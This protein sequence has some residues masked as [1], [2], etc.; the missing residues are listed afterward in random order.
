MNLLWLSNFNHLRRHPWQFGLALIGV[1]LGVAI[2]VAVQ[3]TQHSAKLGFR[4]AQ[5]ALTGIATHRIEAATG[6][7]DERVYARL[8]LSFP[9][10]AMTPVLEADVKLAAKRGEWA[11]LVGLDPLTVLTRSSTALSNAAAAQSELLTTSLGLV[12]A[13]T[14]RLLGQ[15]ATATVILV[16]AEHEFVLALQTPAAASPLND[17][18]LDGVILVDIATAQ[19]LL[20]RPGEIS[21]IELYV[22]K[23]AAGL[24]ARLKNTLPATLHLRD[25]KQELA[26]QEMLTKALDT[27]LAA[28][29]FLG[30]LLGMFL[31]YN[32]ESFLVVQRNVLYG[33]LRTLGVTASELMWGVLIEALLIGALASVVGVC[34]GVLL[35]DAL[36]DLV[37]Y[38]RRDFY[39]AVTTHEL[40]LDAMTLGAC[41]VGG[42][43]TTILAALCPA[44]DAANAPL[45]RAPD[46][47]HAIKSSWL[48]KRVLTFSFILIA[49][50][51]YMAPIS[52]LWRSFAWLFLALVLASRLIPFALR[53]I[54]PGL[55]RALRA[56]SVWPERL[57]IATSLRADRRIE[58]ATT[59]LCLAAAVSLG[60][61]LMTGSFRQNVETWLLRLLRADFYLS[62]RDAPVAAGPQL[63]TVALQLAQ[64]PAVSAISTVSRL[65]VIVDRRRTSLAVYS[66]PPRARP[67]YEFLAGDPRQIWRQWETDDT[68]IVT[69]P[70]ARHLKRQL[71]DQLTIESPTGRRRFKITGIYRDYSSEHGIVAMSRATFQRHWAAINV[72]GVGVYAHN[73]RDLRAIRRTLDTIRGNTRD[74]DIRANVELRQRALQVFDRTFQIT[75][76]LALATLLVSFVGIIGSLLAQQIE[77]ARDYGVL[78]AL[79][80]SRIELARVIVAQTFLIGIVAALLAMPIGI[81]IANYLVRVVN[82]EA[83]GWTMPLVVPLSTLA[84]ASCGVLFAATAAAILP[85]FHATIRPPAQ[86][87]QDE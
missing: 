29:S 41:A 6:V 26:A 75:K 47:D 80:I 63:K 38:T 36:L 8:C 21:H 69:E 58:T 73:S 55:A 15:P 31:V 46:P 17:P 10:L 32:T 45:G 64:H 83:F 68:V 56:R 86:V 19:E 59:A 7:L 13:R 42:V 71:G 77:R 44:L 53:L 61:Q 22:P 35:A 2:V 66:L 25:I 67:G 40:S 78:R 62:I 76:L 85:V 14:F 79:G 12:N 65:R 18:A 87:L 4:R 5:E 60:M 54:R 3:V 30:I 72:E 1:A 37:I 81:G 34:A 24:L 52:T 48:S 20:R 84:Y 23:Q 28:M 50:L 11:K 51:V 27:N 43:V 33:R 49:V 70:Y 57:G 9:N 16:Q 39:Y 74:L 82:V